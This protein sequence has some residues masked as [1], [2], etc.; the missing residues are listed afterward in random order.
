MNW[1]PAP[2]SFCRWHSQGSETSGALSGRRS[3]PEAPLSRAAARRS[4]STR[5][6][7]VLGTGKETPLAPGSLS[8]SDLGPSPT[9]TRVLHT[10][11]LRAASFS[12][13]P[14]TRSASS[15]YAEGN[16]RARGKRAQPQVPSLEVGR[17]ARV[18]RSRISQ[19]TRPVP[20]AV[21]PLPLPSWVLSVSV[22]APVYPFPSLFLAL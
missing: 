19:Q 21:S 17:S 11:S 22:S 8:L 3:R 14:A 2:L 20:R 7:R 18:P 15:V 1:P 16:Q 10:Q 4:G 12:P 6:E 5:K 9:A 13:F